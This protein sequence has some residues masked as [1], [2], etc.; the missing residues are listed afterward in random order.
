MKKAYS[1]DYSI[2]RDKDRAT[3]VAD[4]ID[5]MDKDPSA[6]DLE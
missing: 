4:I 5:H 2:E 6:T 1:L 3:A